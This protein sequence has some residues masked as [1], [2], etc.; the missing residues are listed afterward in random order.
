MAKQSSGQGIQGRLWEL[1]GQIATAM[2]TTKGGGSLRSRPMHP[3]QDESTGTI[4]FFARRTGFPELDRAGG[5]PVSLSYSDPQ[6]EA[7]AAVS[8]TARMVENRDQMRALWNPSVARWFPGGLNDPDM[9]LIEVDAEQAQYWEA[10]E[11]QA[12]QFWLLAR[13][14]MPSEAQNSPVDR[15]LV[16]FACQRIRR[17]S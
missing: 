10:P 12:V 13:S 3:F 6:H 9:V 1:T 2:L 8:G 5:V 11:K 7:Y 15:A 17:A 16:D 14:Q 4:R